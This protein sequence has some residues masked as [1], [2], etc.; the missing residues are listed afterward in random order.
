[1]KKVC[2]YSLSILLILAVF[3]F[4]ACGTEA[5]VPTEEETITAYK[6]AS[7]AYEFALITPF[8]IDETAEAAEIGNYTYYPVI[9]D[10][11]K[12]FADYENYLKEHFSSVL[13]TGYTREVILTYRDHNGSLYALPAGRG[14]DQTLGNENY[15]YQKESD[16]KIILKVEVDTLADDRTTVTG[17]K[18][19][20]FTYELVDGKWV[21]TAFPYF[22]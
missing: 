9:H 8:P 18:M 5:K 22:R 2:K 7:E 20:D 3:S 19:F 4:A 21:F 1:M 12:T 14:Q 16:K 13:V 10:T 15:T 6:A 17:S 11:I